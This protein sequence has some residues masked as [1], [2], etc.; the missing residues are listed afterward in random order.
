MSSKRVGRRHSAPAALQT[1]S[2]TAPSMSNAEMAE[3]VRAKR[4]QERAD[5]SSGVGRLDGDFLNTMND[6]LSNPTSTDDRPRMGIAD[7]QERIME[8][9]GKADPMMRTL[10]GG[11]NLDATHVQAGDV[12]TRRGGLSTA[13]G[14][15]NTA[16]VV[17]RGGDAVYGYGATEFGNRPTNRPRNHV[18]AD[19]TRPDYVERLLP[20]LTNT[21]TGADANGGHS[22]TGRWSEADVDPLTVTTNESGAQRIGQRNADRL[23]HTAAD[24][25]VAGPGGATDIDHRFFVTADH[26][27]SAVPVSPVETDY[28][29]NNPYTPKYDKDGNTR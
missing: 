18:D 8:V 19:P 14:Y 20:S 13:R 23:L 9:A 15:S 6:R 22:R 4:Q 5:E 7:R 1:P 3:R 28:R 16:G 29:A 10:A 25:Q 21:P 26:Y 12:R 11:G 2:T 27:K 24:S 17:T